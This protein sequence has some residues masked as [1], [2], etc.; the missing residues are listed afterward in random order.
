MA[1]K[2]AP[3]AGVAVPAGTTPTPTTTPPPASA[4]APATQPPPASA[5]PPAAQPASPPPAQAQAQK[6][7]PKT[8]ASSSGNFQR[9]QISFTGTLGYGQSFT[10]NYMILGIGLG[11]YIK[12]GLEVGAY[13]ENWLFGDPT[14]QKLSP[15]VRYTRQLPMGV[16]PYVGAYYRRTFIEGLDD[17][18]SYG[19]RV[20]A[21][22]TSRGRSMFGGGVVYEKYLNCESSVYSDCDTFYPEVVFSTSF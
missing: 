16:A 18:D 7:P 11:Y 21:Y 9:G 20:G 2:A 12:N 17:L 15:E 22:K 5:P 3:A 19:G 13:Y 14:V 10:N 6:S 1:A 8:N 4:P